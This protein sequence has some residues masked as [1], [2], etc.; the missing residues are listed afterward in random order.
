MNACLFHTALLQHIH[1]ARV[2][3]T[4]QDYAKII[5]LMQTKIF[6]VL[7]FALAFV[8]YVCDTKYKLLAC[9]GVSC[10]ITTNHQGVRADNFHNFNLCCGF[11]CANNDFKLK[12]LEF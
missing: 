6:L 10:G 9:S 4:C 5:C 2:G 3:A 1:K 7:F 8:N 12:L 11:M